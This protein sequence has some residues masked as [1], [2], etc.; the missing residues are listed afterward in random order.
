MAHLHLPGYMDRVL[1][2]LFSVQVLYSF[3]FRGGQLCT[4]ARVH[5]LWE[6]FHWIFAAVACF[7]E[8]GER[9]IQ[10]YSKWLSGFQQLVIHNTLEIAVHVFLFNR[11]TLQV[12]VTYLTGALYVHPL[13]FYKHQHDNRFRF[14]LSVASQRWWCQW[15][16]WCTHVISFYGVMSRIK[17]MF[18]L[19]PQVSRN[20]RYESEPPLKPSL[21]TCYKQLGTNSI[22]VLMFVESQM[23]H[24]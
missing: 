1:T 12:F 13:W 24:I 17:F 7:F 21:L 18:L 6:C 22:I 4:G 15:R 9:Y 5:C 16:F 20:W 19:F 14:K 11:T 8:K 10:G 2:R 3:A 23:V